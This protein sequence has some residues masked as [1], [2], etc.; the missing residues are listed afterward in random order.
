MIDARLLDGVESLTVLSA[1][2][3]ERLANQLVEV[4][5]E[6]GAVLVREA[7]RAPGL[8][9]LLD[10]TVEVIKRV[11]GRDHR[12][13]STEIPTGEWFG[14]ISVIDGLPA[15]AA[16]CAV[17]EVTVAA[18]SREDFFKLIGSGDPMGA[19]FFRAMLR[20]LALQLAR[21]NGALFDL[22]RQVDEKQP[23]DE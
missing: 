13:M 22:R 23:D 10:G 3:R 1:D 15:T 5:Y 9:L 12:E 19:H 18:L 7:Q 11:Q 14:M 21:I 2:E 8:F 17:S 16:I 20:C 6:P 4:R